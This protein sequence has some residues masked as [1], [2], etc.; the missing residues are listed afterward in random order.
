MIRAWACPYENYL[1]DGGHLLHLQ[2]LGEVKRPRT[3]RGMII[4]PKIIRI[5][6]ISFP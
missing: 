4:A 3:Q 5:V 6:C 2:G 1:E